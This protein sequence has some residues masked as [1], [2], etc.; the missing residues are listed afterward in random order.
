MEFDLG[1]LE[2]SGS[3]FPVID[4]ISSD[5]ATGAYHVSCSDNGTLAYV[6][7]TSGSSDH[8]LALI[9]RKGGSTLLAAPPQA[10]VDPRISPDGKKIAIVIQAGKGFDIWI[11]DIQRSAMSRLTF[12]GS[13]R[14]PVW[15]PDGKRIAYSDNISAVVGK[16]KISIIQADGSGVPQDIMM[17]FDRTY[18]NSWAPDGSV[19]IVTVPQKG[20]V[21]EIFRR[22]IRASIPAGVSIVVIARAGAGSLASAT[23]NNELTAAARN[24]AARMKE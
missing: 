13:N 19:L 1:R 15:S 10:Y 4:N 7:G 22:T 3:S 11:Y 17:D 24:I 20:R 14:S 2:A 5:V 12:G 23:I 16:S 18:V 6:P 9:D 21:R 8:F